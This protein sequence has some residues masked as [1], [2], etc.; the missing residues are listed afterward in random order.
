MDADLRPYVCISEACKNYPIAFGSKKEWEAHMN[1]NHGT[2]WARHIHRVKWRCP[3]CVDD[4]GLFSSE[5]LLV[6][7]LKDLQVESHPQSLDEFELEKIKSEY[8][9]T[10]PRKSNHCPLCAWPNQEKTGVQMREPET[11]FLKHF[12]QHLQQLAL[13]SISWW[14]QDIGAAADDRLGSGHG[15]TDTIR[16][17]SQIDADQEKQTGA[18]F[19]LDNDTLEEFEKT[20]S[21]GELRGQ[22]FHLTL[23]TQLQGLWEQLEP[24]LDHDARLDCERIREEIDWSDLPS[25]EDLFKRLDD[26]DEHLRLKADEAIPRQKRFEQIIGDRV[27]PPNAPLDSVSRSDLEKFNPGTSVDDNTAVDH[28]MK[29]RTLVQEILPSLE[30]LQVPGYNKASFRNAMHSANI[31][32]GPV[33]NEFFVLSPDDLNKILTH[34]FIQTFFHHLVESVSSIGDGDKESVARYCTDEVQNQRVYYS[35][36]T[37]KEKLASRRKLFAILSLIEIPAVVVFFIMHNV[38]DLDLPFRAFFSKPNYFQCQ[39]GRQIP[40]PSGWSDQLLDS[41]LGS[42]RII[43]GLRQDDHVGDVEKPGEYLSLDLSSRSS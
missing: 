17:N 40:L 30:L 11:S 6:S 37:K 15:S 35:S 24:V 9:E 31:Q 12:V 36:E 2:E 16:L 14:E 3:F 20:R 38:S 41:F 27:E 32:L 34:T 43:C 22:G 18:T 23:E 8:K 39:S 10:S 7:H 42:Q 26:L 4:A 25:Q 13:W 33:E 5:D 19:Y 1:S 21:S 29:V 28:M